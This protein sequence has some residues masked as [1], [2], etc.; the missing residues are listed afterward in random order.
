MN[1]PFKDDLNLEY[2]KDEFKRYTNNA[3]Y[4]I[5]QSISSFSHF[6]YMASEEYLVV[7]DLQ[8]KGFMLTDP[9]IHSEDIKT[10]SEST[11]HGK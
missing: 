4:C 8:G 7:T 11:N 1:K 9:A 5:N 3:T 2:S 6:T 10:F